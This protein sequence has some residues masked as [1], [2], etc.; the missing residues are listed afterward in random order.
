MVRSKEALPGSRSKPSAETKGEVAGIAVYLLPGDGNEPFGVE[1]HR[2]WVIVWIVE[3][4]P[5]GLQGE[6]MII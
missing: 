1:H 6:F 3:D 5:V 4:F 2:I